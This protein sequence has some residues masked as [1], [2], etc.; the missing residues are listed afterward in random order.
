MPQVEVRLF[1]EADGTVPMHEWLAALPAKERVKCVVAI[2]LLAAEGHA[3][4]RPHVDLLRDGVYELR[5]G[6]RGQNY[7]MLYFFAAT[8][9]VVV[10]HGLH[11]GATGSPE[12]DR[13][14]R[15]PPATRRGRPGPPL[16]PEVNVMPTAPAPLSPATGRANP[17]DASAA[18]SDGRPVGVLAP[19]G[20]KVT[21]LRGGSGARFLYARYIEGDP[22]REVGFIEAAA[23]LDAGTALYDLRESAGLSEAELAGRMGPGVTAETIEQAEVGDHEDGHWLGLLRRA[24]LACGRRMEIRFVDPEGKAPP[25][26][27]RR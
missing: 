8:V 13:P 22:E 7:R 12:G 10:S 14:R 1:R 2:D 16:D 4:R 5:V 17:I 21:G 15:R 20:S 19:D 11:Q 9:A 23:E 6:R 18:P 26:E 25:V 24:A 27:A 3:L